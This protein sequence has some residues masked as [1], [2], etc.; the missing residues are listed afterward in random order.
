MFAETYFA[1]K[2]HVQLDDWFGDVD[3]NNPKTRR[4]RV[5]SLHCFWPGMEASLGLRDSST[6]L[7]NAFFAVWN[8]HGFFPEEFDQV[9]QTPQYSL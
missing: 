2:R 9:G 8:A 6:K 1:V 5:E 3:M 4:N 7:L